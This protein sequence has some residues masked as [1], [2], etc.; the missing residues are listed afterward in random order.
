MNDTSIMRLVE[1]NI[2]YDEAFLTWVSNEHTQHPNNWSWVTWSH[3]QI[4]IP[5]FWTEIFQ[6][7]D[8]SKLISNKSPPQAQMVKN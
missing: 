2:S 4:W 5:I 1:Q 7:I 3:T 8:D 6:S